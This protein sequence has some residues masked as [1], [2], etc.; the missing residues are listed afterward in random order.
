MIKGSTVTLTAL[1]PANADAVRAWLHDPRINEWLAAGHVPISAAAERAFYEQAERDRGRAAAHHFE[2]HA[3]DDMRLLGQCSL[4]DI[5]LIDRHG[6]LGIF[7]GEPTE[8]RKG[9][10]SDALIALLRFAFHTIGL[11]TARIR[12]VTGNERAITLYRSIGFSVA[13]LFREA[14]YVRG[15]FHDVALLDMTRAEFDALYGD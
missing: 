6:E 8:H 12:A 2:I 4:M 13:G 3:S 10:G 1:D 14:R 5:D 9:F 7:I 11:R 15:R